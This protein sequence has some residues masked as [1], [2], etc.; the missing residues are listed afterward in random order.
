MQ[1]LAPVQDQSSIVI[2]CDFADENGDAVTPTAVTWTLTDGNGDVVND[3]Q[4]KT[5]SP[6]QTVYIPLQG[7]DLDYNEEAE[8]DGPGWPAENQRILVAS[9]TYL[10]AL[11]GTTLL[12]NAGARFDIHDLPDI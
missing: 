2:Q 9:A 5:A 10:S 8:S 6:A 11:T 4:N 1:R 12:V 3:R 7:D